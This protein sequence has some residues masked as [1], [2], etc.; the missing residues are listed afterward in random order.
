M[1]R[2]PSD[3]ALSA[4]KVEAEWHSDGSLPLDVCLNQ[5]KSQMDCIQSNDW[6]EIEAMLLTQAYALQAMFTRYAVKLSKM[7]YLNS[8]SVYAALA[9]KAQNQCRQTL[10][11]LAAIRSNTT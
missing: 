10:A 2:I 8:I 11:T 1:Q 9:F 5:M 3:H 7:E 6:S 4:S